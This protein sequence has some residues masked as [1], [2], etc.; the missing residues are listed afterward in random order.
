MNL[1]PYLISRT[2]THTLFHE[3]KFTLNCTNSSTYSISWAQVHIQFHELK[4]ILN[5]TLSS[6]YS[7]SQAQAHIRFYELKFILNF[8][9]SN[10]YLISRTFTQIST[11][12]PLGVGVAC[13][14]RG[15]TVMTFDTK[16]PAISL[17][18]EP[19]A[20]R[21]RNWNIYCG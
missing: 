2:Q 4:H 21:R 11:G 1:S 6:S 17:T 8:T 7:I 5:F 18:A 10:T 14:L 3:L 9:S 20:R 16:F 15:K 13:S 12:F 19:G